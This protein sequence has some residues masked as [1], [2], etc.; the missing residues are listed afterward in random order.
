M[1]VDMG[2]QAVGRTQGWGQMWGHEAG[3]GAW[4]WGWTWGMGAVGMGQIWG[5]GEGVGAWGRGWMQGVGGGRGDAMGGR[6]RGVGQMRGVGEGGGHEGVVGGADAG[7][8]GRG[9]QRLRCFRMWTLQ[10]DFRGRPEKLIRLRN[11][12][13]EVEWTGAWSDE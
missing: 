12:W 5:C 11:P 1:V 10:V 8:P 4:G 3:A 7:A 6:R 9:A 2:L 13:G